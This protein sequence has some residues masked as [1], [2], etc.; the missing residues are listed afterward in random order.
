MTNSKTAK[1]F[2]K[3]NLT[4]AIT[5]RR[6]DGYHTLCSVMQSISLCNVVKVTRTDSGAVTLICD[7]PALPLN[8]KNTAYR[9][10]KAFLDASKLRTGT[11]L[12]IEVQ[13][14]IPYQAGL[15]SA[16]ADAA[17]VLAAANALFD[18]PLSDKKLLETAASI[19]ADVP[20]CLAGGT[21]LAEGIGEIFTTLPSCPE[22]TLLILHPN[23]GVSTPEAYKRF[24]ELKN[25][26]QPKHEAMI[27]ALYGGN[28]QDVA[29]ACGNVFEQCCP[30]L[31]VEKMKA[32]LLKR[33]ALGC[34]MSG[35]GTAVF[36]IFSNESLAESAR[37]ALNTYGWKSWIANP[38]NFGV[39]VV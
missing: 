31:A 37:E 14:V 15:G 9:A 21:R 4:L 5:G 13:K 29:S 28:L 27:S 34:A 10:A 12:L 18:Y 2:G 23:E 8:S 17:G 38:V 1:A 30:V 3:I 20:F 26:V 11:G 24:D 6:G 19:G 22:C 36:G 33:G 35:S 32:E 39:S 7:D 16:S 25:P